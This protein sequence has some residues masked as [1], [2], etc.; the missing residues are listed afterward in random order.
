MNVLVTGAPG[1]GKTSLVKGAHKQN[2]KQLFDTDEIPRL[3][4]WREYTTGKIL[5]LVTE[6]KATGDEWYTKYGWY[7]NINILT[8]FLKNNPDA[9][10]CGSSENVVE[11]YQ[12][13]DKIFL[14]KKTEQEL[15]NNLASPERVNPFG[16]TPEQR[17]NFLN[18]QNHLIKGLEKYKHTI[19]HGNEIRN[20][21]SDIR[22]QL[23]IKL[24]I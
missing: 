8:Q 9:I 7:W 15:L 12:Y 2:D 10:L 5:G 4:E 17:K 18:W 11:C 16:K 19:L 1:S 6:Y 23:K 21:Y 22:E 14:L 24:R 3:C 20:S 13:F